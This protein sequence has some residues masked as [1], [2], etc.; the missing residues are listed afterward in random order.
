MLEHP[1]TQKSIAKLKSW[2][3]N[4]LETASGRLACGDEGYGKMP[5]PDVILNHINHILHKSPETVLTPGRL[6]I[7]FGGTS[8]KIDQVRE[9]SNI[10]T[11]RTGAI[12]AGHFLTKN[13]EVT[14]LHADQAILPETE[15]RR[16]PFSGF[17]SLNNSLKNI[18]NEEKFSCIIHL[19]AVS[20][21]SPVSALTP[22]KE[23]TIPVEG[24]LDSRHEEVVLKLK[25]NP[26]ILNQIKAYAKKGNPLLVAFKLTSGETEKMVRE[27]ISGMKIDSGAD[28]VIWNDI[29]DRISG[30]QT[31][32]FIFS[33]AEESP[34]CC[35]ETNILARKLEELLSEKIKTV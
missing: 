14:C 35:P 15:C 29:A 2:G 33:S 22:D 12:I 11:G 30:K 16:I 27:K 9:L 1:A 8:E 18:L 24:K 20:D 17:E 4:V 13:W 5:E 34:Y 19:A 10:S 7:T 25:K 26:K 32:Y 21:Y 23:F 3:V 6:L 28:L 31:R